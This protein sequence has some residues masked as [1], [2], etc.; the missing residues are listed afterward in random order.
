LDQIQI[1]QD[2][3][4]K[5]NTNLLFIFPAFDDFLDYIALAAFEKFT[6][7]KNVLASYPANFSLHNFSAS[8]LDIQKTG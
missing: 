2:T 8:N 4:R 1:H 3:N 7:K 6:G 5:E